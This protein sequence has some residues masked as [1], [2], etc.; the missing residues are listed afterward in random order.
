M[1]PI[2][3]SGSHVSRRSIPT[4]APPSNGRARPNQLSVACGWGAPCTGSGNCMVMRVR[5]APGWMHF[6]SLQRSPENDRDKMVRAD[7]LKGAGHLA[8]VQADHEAATALLAESLDLYRAQTNLRGIAHVLNIQGMIANER[9]EYARAVALFE[10]S[11]ALWRELGDV[12][13]IGATPE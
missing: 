13:W 6:L 7:A 4:C 8:W 5:D 1:G 11:L 3:A 12:T 9:G 2:S 10:E